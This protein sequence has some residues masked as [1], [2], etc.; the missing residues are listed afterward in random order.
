MLRSMGVKLVEK[1]GGIAHYTRQGVIQLAIA[2]LKKN[3][4]TPIQVGQI[5][6]RYLWRQRVAP[7]FRSKNETIFSYT[8]SSAVCQMVSMLTDSISP[9]RFLGAFAFMCATMCLA[10]QIAVDIGIVKVSSFSMFSPP[11][12]FWLNILCIFSAVKANS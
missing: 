9:G 12:N 5:A 8:G 7:A 3:L 2:N 1:A 10:A 6:A 4:Q 11:F